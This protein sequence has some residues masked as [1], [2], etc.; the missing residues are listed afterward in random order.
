[1]RGDDEQQGAMWSYISPEQRVPEDHPLRPI[2]EMVNV[3]LKDMSPSFSGI[4]SREGRPSIPP[5]HLLRALLLQ[6]LSAFAASGC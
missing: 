5:E 2:R 6:V 4:Y 1:M 3:V